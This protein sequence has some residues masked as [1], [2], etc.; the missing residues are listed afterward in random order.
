M[1]RSSAHSSFTQGAG[2]TQPF[3]PKSIFLG[4]QSSCGAM[5]QP[6]FPTPCAHAVPSCPLWLQY[7]SE[8]PLQY[9]WESNGKSSQP[10]SFFFLI[11]VK[12]STLGK[13][14]KLSSGNWKG[15]TITYHFSVACKSEINQEIKHQ[16]ICDTRFVLWMFKAFNLCSSGSQSWL[17]GHYYFTYFLRY[18][19]LHL[20]NF[21][22]VFR[23]PLCT[24]WIN[25]HSSTSSVPFS[26]FWFIIWKP[27]MWHQW[28]PQCQQQGQL[29]YL[30]LSSLLL[31]LRAGPGVSE[32]Q[33]LLRQ[34]QA[35]AELPI[36][37]KLL[38]LHP[39]G[40]RTSPFPSLHTGSGQ[41]AWLRSVWE[42]WGAPQAQCEAGPHHQ[43]LALVSCTEK[44]GSGWKKAQ[45]TTQQG[46]A[47]WWKTWK[48]TLQ[49]LFIQ[50]HMAF[51]LSPN[52]GYPRG[53]AGTSG[54]AGLCP[55]CC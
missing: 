33:P 9:S 14:C 52:P 39:L 20:K 16:D 29:C 46:F 17:L 35:R 21:L 51:S 41:G 25:L 31:P 47:D 5:C 13:L 1:P 55:A 19:H 38:S 26:A 40:H 18:N 6:L 28:S 37:T 27:S 3:H 36:T 10:G 43:S 24:T 11:S 2:R 48:P 12:F 44:P 7:K 53:R 30:I 42:S 49:H 22:A 54:P 8:E 32:P 50:C 34:G 15:K 45:Q 4:F 23:I